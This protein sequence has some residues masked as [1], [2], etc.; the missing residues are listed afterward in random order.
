MI[1]TLTGQSDSI[2][3]DGPNMEGTLIGGNL[4]AMQ[5]LIGTPYAHS[6]QNALLL[7][8]DINDHYSRYD[9]MI[10]HMKQAGWVNDLNGIISG[11]FIN[12][13]DNPDRPF[14]FDI[15]GILTMNAPDTPTA[16]NSPFGHGKNLCTLPIGAKASLKNNKLSFKALDQ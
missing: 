3:I 1:D 11:E 15:E 4:S 16:L 5:A 14:G 13:L 12:S 6:A 10:A 8:E 9:R 2:S 7:I